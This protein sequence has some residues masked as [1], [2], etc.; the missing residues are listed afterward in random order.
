M[1]TTPTLRPRT[2]GT[3][4]LLLLALGQLIVVLDLSIVNVALADIQTDLG[5]SDAGLAWVVNGYAIAFAGFLLF[6]GRLADLVGRRRIFLVGLAIFGVASLAAAVSGSPGVLIVSR[7]VQGFGGALLSP[8]TLA[9][10]TT[11]F[12]EGKQRARAT[13][14][15]G[16]VAGAGAALGTVLGGVLTNIGGWRWVFYVNLPLVAIAIVGTLVLV[17][18]SAAEAARRLDGIGAVLVTGALI[19]LVLGTINA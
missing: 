13:A 10:L 19:A 16:A 9:L 15:W 14:T 1:S 7:V 3:G 8:A 11:T 4:T 12:P 18:E 17:K 5:F 6:G 2:A